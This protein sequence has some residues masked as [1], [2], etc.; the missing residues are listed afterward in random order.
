MGSLEWFCL[1][2]SHLIEGL[3][4][5]DQALGM[6]ARSTKERAKA[7]GRGLGGME[8]AYVRQRGRDVLDV[9]GAKGAGA[10]PF[11]NLLIAEEERYIKKAEQDGT[12]GNWDKW[13][14]D[15]LRKTREKLVG[16]K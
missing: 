14:L 7:L 2:H 12:L 4:L 3:A 9:L 10:L 15:N 8:R 1:I 16:K 6:S 11:I 13:D 5:A